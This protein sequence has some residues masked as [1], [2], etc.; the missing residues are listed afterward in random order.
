M[1]RSCAGAE[2]RVLGKLSFFPFILSFKRFCH[3]SASSESY[4]LD[5]QALILPQRIA[6]RIAT[7]PVRMA[8][9]AV[10][11]DYLEKC[12]LPQRFHNLVVAGALLNW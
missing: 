3:N 6:T 4:Y 10:K 9:L 1:M 5:S 2:C 7:K 12:R 11:K 8:S